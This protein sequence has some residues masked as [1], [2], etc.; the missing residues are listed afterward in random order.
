MQ[1]LIDRRFYRRKYDA[2][3]TVAAFGAQA[4]DEVELEQLTARLVAVVDET[5]RP[6]AVSLWLPKTPAAAPRSWRPGA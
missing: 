4:R 3:R 5:M 6:A 1:G 2:A